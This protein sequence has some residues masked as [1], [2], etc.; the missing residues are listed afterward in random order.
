MSIIITIV[1]FNKDA[2]CTDVGKLSV[3]SFVGRTF[4]MKKV[5]SIKL[6]ES[7]ICCS[8][9]NADQKFPWT[10]SPKIKSIKDMMI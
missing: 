3:Y 1:H 9:N 7:E 10:R 5:A 8:L 6:A 2:C 4:Y